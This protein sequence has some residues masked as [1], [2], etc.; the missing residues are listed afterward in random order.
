MIVQVSVLTKVLDESIAFYEK[1]MG[2][3]II[4]DVRPFGP[5]IVFMAESADDPATLELIG[6]EKPYQGEGVY[7][8]IHDDDPDK[9]RALFIEKGLEVS[10]IAEPEPG[11]RLFFVKDPNG[12]QVK[13][14]SA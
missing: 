1:Y 4:K 7:L 13:V 8:G 12:L 2:F 6:S 5:P 11:V 14:T 10:E 3:Q 9:K